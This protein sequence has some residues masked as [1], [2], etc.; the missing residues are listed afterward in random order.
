MKNLKKVIALLL[1]TL[2]VV[3]FAAC[4]KDKDSNNPDGGESQVNANTSSEIYDFQIELYGDVYTLPADLNKFKENGWTYVNN[5]NP[6]SKEVRANGYATCDVL[7]EGKRITLTAINLSANTKTFSECKVGSIDC[8]FSATN[9]VT[10]KLANNLL[11]TKETTVKDVTNKFGEPSKNI[12]NESGTTVRY[13][14]ETYV[15][16]V[17]SFNTEGKLTYVDMRNW[18][19]DGEASS[20]EVDLSF[21]EFYKSP[22]ALTDNY[23]DYIF[24]LEGKM[25][26]LPAPV[27]AF[28]EN[29]WTLTSYPDSIPA[30]NEITA[31]LKMKKGD[32]ELTFTIKNFA[33]GAVETKDTM[34]TGVFVNNEFAKKI[35]FE[36]SGGIV[37]DMLNKDFEAKSYA[38]EFTTEN[39]ITGGTEYSHFEATNRVYLTFKDGKLVNAN[40]SKHTLN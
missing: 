1:T 38:S 23:S 4:S 6:E 11:V 2:M 12:E 7:K 29:G 3:S 25:Y 8:T 19:N 24:R 13:E 39:A 18:K 37:F 16:Y 34:V 20:N 27:S 30:G 28:V 35:D 33:S 36:L 15:Y 40:F 32:I 22:S 21:L 14:K 9:D 31:G 10:F 17:F 5:E 26:Q